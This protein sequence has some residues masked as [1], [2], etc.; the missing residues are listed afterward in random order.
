MRMI[1]IIFSALI[2]FLIACGPVNQRRIPKPTNTQT[3]TDVLFADNNDSLVKIII[4]QPPVKYC[5]VDHYH[6]VDI[7]AKVKIDSLKNAG[8]TDILFYRDW[9]G[10]NGSNGYGKLIWSQNG[11]C[12]QYQFNFENYDGRY[13][14]SSIDKSEQQTCDVI[15]FYLEKQI[16]TVTSS[17][18]EPKFE[19]SHAA[20]HFPCWRKIE[21]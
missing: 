19:M 18:K 8:I 6:F 20:D 4:N 3:I 17:P 21:A 13:G 1:I 14:I 11:K 2:T 5:N 7:V 15:N 10:T 16:D 12:Y 9:I